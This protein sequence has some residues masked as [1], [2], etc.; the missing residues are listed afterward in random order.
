MGWAA[1]F[2]AGSQVARNALD[3]YYGAKERKEIEDLNKQAPETYEGVSPQNQQFLKNVE[4]AVDAQGNPVYQLDQATPGRFGLSVRNAEGGY[5]PVEGPGISTPREQRVRYLGREYGAEQFNPDVQRAARTQALTDIVSKYRPAEGVRLGLEAQKAT[6]EAEARRYA[7]SQRPMAERQ[8]AATVESL[9]GKV[10]AE[11]RAETREVNLQNA[12]TALGEAINT[13]DFDFK[14]WLSTQKLSPTDRIALQ[15]KVNKFGLGQV[16]GAAIAADQKYI[17]FQDRIAAAEKQG[18]KIDPLA[19]AREMGLSTAGKTKYFQEQYGVND[20]E[21]KS[22]QKYLESK[23]TSV[24]N[25]EGLRELHKSDPN[26]DPGQHF[27]FAEGPD[28][29]VTVRMFDTKTNEP[30]A[31]VAPRVFKNRDDALASLVAEAKGA[32]SLIAYTATKR[33]TDLEERW[34]E[35]QIKGEDAKTDFVNEQRKGLPAQAQL[36]TE[37]AS[38]VKAQTAVIPAESRA[39]VGLMAAQGRSADASANLHNAQGAELSKVKASNIMPLVNDTT[40]DVI[41]VDVTKMERNANGSLAVPNGYK[42]QKVMTDQQKAS[43][44]GYNKILAGDTT[45]LEPANAA[46]RE[47]LVVSLGLQGIVPV[48]G[49]NPGSGTDRLGPG[50]LNAPPRAGAAAPAAAPVPAYS[51]TSLP[52]TDRITAAV[53][54]DRSA[55]NNYQLGRLQQEA[56]TTVPQLQSQ[57]ATLKNSMNQ[58]TPQQKASMEARIGELEKA[59]NAYSGLL[60]QQGLR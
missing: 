39:K 56:Q 18:I 8:V 15:E 25:L 24:K 51:N 7:V 27:D 1:G 34:K 30:L 21:L 33:K 60:P 41:L 50:G 11:G 32:D 28:G 14:N 36:W 37:Q 49:I 31:N 53:N 23:L 35:A 9:E 59:L 48:R 47:A 45:L 17:D 43:L 22:N 38:H 42:P 12:E 4:S 44:E 55:G 29:K 2:Q 26:F 20:A 19:L 5:T 10:R 13:P 40:G 6:D 3:A 16:A 46:K 58:G 54:A 52:I 57:I